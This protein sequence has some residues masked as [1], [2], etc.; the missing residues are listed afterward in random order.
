[1]YTAHQHRGGAIP[2]FPGLPDQYLG[3]TKCHSATRGCGNKTSD[4]AP[5]FLTN[6]FC[7][8]LTSSS[9]P[10]PHSLPLSPTLHAKY[11]TVCYKIV[12]L[13]QFLQPGGEREGGEGR[14]ERMREST[15][16][17]R[18]LTSQTQPIPTCIFFSITHRE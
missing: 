4:V 10:Y 17:N 5:N 7:P 13:D 8:V 3:S 15:T 9:P 16:S 12:S 11:W 2:S 14:R 18:S 6:N 1:M